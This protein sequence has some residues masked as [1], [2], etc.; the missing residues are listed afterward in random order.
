MKIKRILFDIHGDER[1][2]LVAIEELKSIPFDIKRVYYMYNTTSK[3][4]RGKHAHKKLQQ[5]MI[6]LNGFCKLHLDDGEEK[7]TIDLNSPNEGIY[8][9]NN[10]WREMSDFSDDCVLLVLASEYYDENDYIRDYQDFLNYI[11]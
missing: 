1:G 9:T 11:K 6:C 5:V 8:I 10:I 4:I 3:V 7:Q 2:Q